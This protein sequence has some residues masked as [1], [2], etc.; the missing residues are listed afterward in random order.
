MERWESGVE[1]RMPKGTEIAHNY[2]LDHILDYIGKG[3]PV[4]W[5]GELRVGMGCASPLSSVT[6]KG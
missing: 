4:T 6:G 5:A 1:T 3:S 2:I